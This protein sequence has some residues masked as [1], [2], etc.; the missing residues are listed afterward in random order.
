MKAII[1]PLLLLV[2][3]AAC[4][5]D[6]EPLPEPEPTPVSDEC[7]SFVPFYEQN[8]AASILRL[9]CDCLDS[10]VDIGAE[11]AMFDKVERFYFDCGSSEFDLIPR[12]PSVTHLTTEVTT[13]NILAFPNLEVLEN[14][15]FMKQALSQQILFLGKLRALILYNAINIPTNIRSRPLEVFSLTYQNTSTQK[16]QLPTNLNR[17]SN[18]KELNLRDLDIALFS[19]YEELINLEYLRL[20]NLTWGRIP[21]TPDQ[22]PKLRELDLYE[23]DIRGQFPDIFAGMDSLETV[24]IGKTELP[25]IAQQRLYQAPNLQEL[26]LSHCEMGEIPNEIGNLSSLKKLI[27]LTDQNTLNT[28]ISLPITVENLHQLKSIYISTNTDQFPLG[29]LK[30]KNSLEDITI[31]DE[32]GSIPSEIG[33]F[34]ALKSL[35]L[36][37]CALT[38]LPPEIEKLAQSLQVLRLSNNNFDASTQ[39]QIKAWL[40]NTEVTF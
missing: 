18:L 5:P 13:A 22:W 25:T 31:K 1:S 3:F 37:D 23:V 15:V 4:R 39:A 20:S 33:D 17:L 8:P 16:I 7:D 10:L 2:C 36:Q 27:I 21:Q 30:L 12:M 40:P 35:N 14:K 28:P 34:V 11:L 38:S 19:G 26:T 32:I 6:L 29:L 24:Y 9:N